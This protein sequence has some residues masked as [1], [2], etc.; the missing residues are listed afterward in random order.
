[1]SQSALARAIGV[2]KQ[3]VSAVTLGQAAFSPETLDR[4]AEV[5][6]CQIADLLPVDEARSK[7]KQLV[8]LV[9]LGSVSF[10]PE[11]L[12][13]IAEVLGCE[14]ADLSPDDLAT[15]AEVLGCEVD[16]L[17][18]GPVAELAGLARRSA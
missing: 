8:T 11:D 2:S 13:K 7:V 4:V 10:G 9:S 1:M 18:P 3:L 5:L 15:V 12:G 17:V 6:G 14:V 16:D